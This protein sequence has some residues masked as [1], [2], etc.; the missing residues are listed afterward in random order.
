MN[1][2]ERTVKA[3]VWFQ[4][5]DETDDKIASDIFKIPYVYKMEIVKDE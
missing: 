1:I 5:T 4:I 3:I 2:E